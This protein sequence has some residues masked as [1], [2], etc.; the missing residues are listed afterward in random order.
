MLAERSRSCFAS[1]MSNDA[2]LSA[3]SKESLICYKREE[4]DKMKAYLLLLHSL[5]FGDWDRPRC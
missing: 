5:E 3:D 2:F 4:K 1:V